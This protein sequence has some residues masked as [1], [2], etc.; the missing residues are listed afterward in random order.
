MKRLVAV[1]LLSSFAMTCAPVSS[2]YIYRHRERGR[3]VTISHR[4]GE[5]ID[6]AE[7]EQFGLFHGIEGFE[8]AKFYAIGNGGY[9]VEITTTE[10]IL[11]AANCDS[12]AIVILRDHINRFEEIAK[13][14]EEFE[15]QWQIVDYDDLGQPITKH[16][17]N[18]YKGAVRG[19][20]GIGCCL[21]GGL[22]GGLVGFNIARGQDSDMS[23]V[24]GALG[25]FLL[26]GPVGVLVG[27][28]IERGIV[29]ARILEARKPMVVE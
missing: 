29:L 23:I 2:Q 9:E 14:Q 5:T 4:V 12:L 21:G 6:V 15:N 13:A 26:S 10:K 3:T 16:E 20:F 28:K 8:T 24:L 11:L 17:L 18:R 27:N 25:G 1:V 22:I 19:M 7:R